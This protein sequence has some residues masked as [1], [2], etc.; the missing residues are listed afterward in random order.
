MRGDDRGSDDIERRLQ[1]LNKEIARDRKAQQPHPTRPP[2]PRGSRRLPRWAMGLVAAL[3]VIGGSIFL[4]VQGHTPSGLSGSADAS[5]APSGPPTDP[6]SNSPANG[7]ADGAAGITVPTGEQMG[8]FSA[9][10]VS[11]AYATTRDLLIAQDLNWPTL[12]GGFPSAYEQAL[13]SWNRGKFVADLTKKGS[14]DSRGYVTTFAPGTTAFVTQVVKV[15]GTMSAA[16]TAVSGT[17]V[18]RVQ[19]DY[20]FTYAVEPP[21]KP[22]DWMRVVQQRYGSIYFGPSTAF[23]IYDFNL[24]GNVAGVDCGTTDGY[25]HPDFPQGPPSSVPASGP[26]VNPYSLATPSAGSSACSPTTGT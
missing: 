9:A 21:G 22:D 8:P 20:L 12:R 16:P 5:P 19:F 6:F 17:E 15:H 4:S 11:S 3:V 1:E 14:D 24:A 2:R 26:A 25:I 13:P 23:A 7:W 18:L 10:Q